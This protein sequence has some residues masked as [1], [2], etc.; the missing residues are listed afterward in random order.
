MYTQATSQAMFDLLRDIY[1]F[2]DQATSDDRFDELVVKYG[3]PYDSAVVGM[4]KK[5]FDVLKQAMREKNV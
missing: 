1:E 4:H 2:E 5:V 3:S